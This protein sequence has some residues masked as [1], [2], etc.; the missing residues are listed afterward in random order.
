MQPAPE[1]LPTRSLLVS[2]SAVPRVSARP[3]STS[4]LQPTPSS[5]PTAGTSRKAPF[6]LRL[7][8]GPGRCA[9]RVELLHAGSWGTVCD[10]GWGLLDAAVVCR[11]L[12]CG[13]AH[14]ALRSAHFGP[15]TGPIWLDEVKCSGT[16][17]AL[18]HCPAEPWGRHNCDHQEDAAVI[19]TGPEDLSPM[20]TSPSPPGWDPASTIPQRPLGQVLATIIPTRPQRQDP[21]TTVIRTTARSTGQ[22]PDTNVPS[23]TAR[24]SGE[25]PAISV[26]STTTRS[27]GQGRFN[28]TSTKA[29]RDPIRIIRIT[30]L[31]AEQ[32]PVGIIQSTKPKAAG[33]TRLKAGREPGGPTRS[34][35]GWDPAG[36]NRSKVGRDSVGINKTKVGLDLVGTN[37][38]K[39]GRDSVGINKTKVRLDPAGTNRSKV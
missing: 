2:P 38:S 14:K 18:W 35:V 36:T 31:K 25:D 32:D 8:G 26:P 7:A 28:A 27:A 10:D 22:D 34:K 24:S 11:Q 5:Q 23:T 3:R 15:G 39:V 17:A 16:E 13:A 21:A 12:G 9:G 30:R 20:G 29:G 37:R 1:Q 33:V 6:L 4:S 19:C